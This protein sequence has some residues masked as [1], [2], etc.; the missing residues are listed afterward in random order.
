MTRALADGGCAQATRGA[1]GCLCGAL[2]VV[3]ITRAAG[4]HGG[5]LDGDGPGHCFALQGV[6]LAPS[7]GSVGNVISGARVAISNNRL[8][9]WEP[10]G[11]RKHWVVHLTNGLGRLSLAVL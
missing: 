4:V 7:G 8:V 6:N 3:L 9:V 11:L 5:A 2:T 10:D 1:N